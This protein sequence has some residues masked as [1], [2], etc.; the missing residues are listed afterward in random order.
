[1]DT[2]KIKKGNVKMIAH[3]G[4]SGLEQEN[5]CAAFVAA[6]NRDYYGIETDIHV[7]ADGEFIVIHDFETAR[8]ATVDLPV[9]S[10]TFAQLRE[11]YLKDKEEGERRDLRLPSLPEY[12]KICRR[13]NKVC[14]LELKNDFS[15]ESLSKLLETVKQYIPLSEIVF[16]SFWFQ[17]LVL[18]RELS[19]EVTLQYLCGEEI[20]EAFIAKLKSCGAH[21]DTHYSFLTAENIVL[22]HENGI[23]VNCWTVD[24][25]AAAEQLVSWGV[26]MITSNI[27]Q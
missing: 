18:L 21:I 8:V 6:G 22:L 2:I 11:I 16:I 19:E 9:E 3:R 23:T 20:N 4:L 1:M 25:P 14:V 27:L 5:T 24:D 17:N 10:S 13:Y 7:T 26:D 15:P 12:L